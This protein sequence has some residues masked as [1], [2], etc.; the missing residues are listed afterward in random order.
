MGGCGIRVPVP[1]GSLTDLTAIVRRPIPAEAINAAFSEAS[2]ARYA[3]ILEYTHDPVVSRDII[4]NTHS[5][6]IE[7][8][9]ISVV[10]SQV[11]IMAWF[12]NEFGYTSRIIDWLGY[13][14][15]MPI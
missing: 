1:D 10:G 2:R 9:L 14:Q 15:R 5:C 8:P 3:G 7:G 12:D 6:V 13:W 11:K 4:G